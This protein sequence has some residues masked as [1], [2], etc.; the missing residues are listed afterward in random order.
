MLWTAQ[1]KERPVPQDPL[2]LILLYFLLP[3]WLAAGFADWLCH[4]A[5]H[6]ETT[7]GPKESALHLLQFGEMGIALLA[8]LFLNINAAVLTLMI[9]MFA[10]HEGTALW[11]VAYA[12]DR[13]NVTPIEQHIHSFLEIIPLTAII[14]VAALHWNQFLALFGAGPDT[15]DFSLS[16]KDDPLSPIYIAVLMVAVMG[17]AVIPYSEELLRGL[18]AQRKHHTNSN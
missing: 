18:R 1:H 14:C 15:A 4:R 13:R 7:S 6:I 3:L 10:I 11:D 8:G 17:L 2:A 9:A 16:W 5:T 12:S